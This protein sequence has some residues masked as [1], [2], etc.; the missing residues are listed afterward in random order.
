MNSSGVLQ[1]LS[2]RFADFWWTLRYC[3]WW[4]YYF[5]RKQR[6]RLCAAVKRLLYVYTDNFL[7]ALD[8]IWVRLP[9]FAFLS[10]G[11][12]LVLD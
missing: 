11:A 6:I 10:A 7:A 1:R 8:E 9:P 5:L 4:V 2:V 12:L 3:Y